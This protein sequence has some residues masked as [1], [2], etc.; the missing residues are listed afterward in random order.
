MKI[1]V[2]TEDG[3][4]ISQHFGR[5]PYYLIATVE[6]GEIINRELIEKLGHRHFVHEPHE[7]EKPGEPHG[8]SESA[9]NRHARMA[10]AIEDCQALL[11]GGMGR[12]A[13]ESLSA[14]GI[15]SVITDISSI[16]EAL[17][18]YIEGSIVNLFERVH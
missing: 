2:V 14:R 8:M 5:A 18:A 12:G 7:P 15:K 1:A 11:S 16:E 10:L 6:N 3:E 17:M 9:Q 4:T 13:Y